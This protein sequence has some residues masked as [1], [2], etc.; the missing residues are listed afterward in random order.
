MGVILKNTI[1]KAF[2][3]LMAVCLLLISVNVT[4]QNE[5]DKQVIID[6]EKA[7]A[8]LLETDPG[9]EK[10]FDTSTGYVIFPN[11]GKGALIIGG[12]MGN[13]VV[14][15]NEQIIGMAD[16]KNLSLGMQAGGESHIEIIFFETKK[17]LEKFKEGNFEF[18]ARVSAIAADKGISKD[19][20]YSE[21]VLVITLPK[22]GIMADTSV[23][24]QKFKYYPFN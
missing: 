11:V 21:N 5:K 1:M 17:A 2:K 20:N 7:K 23:G 14:Y 10:F 24:G 18:S 8:T 6:A 22:K 13:G 19:A 15:E 9:L 16:L 12:S 4:A 3:T